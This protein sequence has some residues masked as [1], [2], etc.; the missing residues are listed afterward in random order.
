MHTFNRDILDGKSKD[1]G[2]DH[3]QGHLHVA[4]NN[5]CRETKNSKITKSP[6][7]SLENK[8]RTKYN[9]RTTKSKGQ[10]TIYQSTG[11]PWR[12]QTIP[13][14]YRG[15]LVRMPPSGSIAMATA[16]H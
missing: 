9:N 14:P 3:T 7:L 13:F 10:E 8:V 4:I 15:D 12:V 5:F 1:D 2:P 11:V 6:R 16:N